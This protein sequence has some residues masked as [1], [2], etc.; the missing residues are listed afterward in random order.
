MWY[1]GLAGDTLGGIR[2]F[3]VVGTTSC[4]FGF[5]LYL[6]VSSWQKRN[7][8][9]GC[10]V[11]RWQFWGG[12]LAVVHCWST[13][14]AWSPQLKGV[15]WDHSL[16]TQFLPKL[17]ANLSSQPI[18]NFVSQQMLLQETRLRCLHQFC[19]RR[20]WR[21]LGCLLYQRCD[22]CTAKLWLLL[23]EC[24]SR[25]IVETIGLFLVR[26]VEGTFPL[27]QR[28]QHVVVVE[29]LTKFVANFEE[30]Q[31]HEERLSLAKHRGSLRLYSVLEEHYFCLN[32]CCT[33]WCGKYHFRGDVVSKISADSNSITFY[34][35]MSSLIV[36]AHLSFSAGSLSRRLAI[37]RSCAKA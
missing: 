26:P 16:V 5:C 10:E 30:D 22:E 4:V 8:L 33:G 14:L 3:S 2:W 32:G 24:L 1:L 36:A 6:L 28:R 34:F 17:D 15:W 7:L 9:V 25:W 27:C 20:S 37:D 19:S 21:K 11:N 18:R 29:T 23:K 13:L 35:C 31:V 12:L